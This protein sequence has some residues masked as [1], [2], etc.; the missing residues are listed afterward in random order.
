MSESEFREALQRDL[1][2]KRNEWILGPFA[3][4]PAT[5]SDDGPQ[6]CVI[7]GQ[8]LDMDSDLRLMLVKT[9]AKNVPA[10]AVNKL[11][12][13][14]EEFLPRN[15]K[16]QSCMAAVANLIP[17]ITIVDLK[18]AGKEDRAMGNFDTLNNF[19]FFPINEAGLDLVNEIRGHR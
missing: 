2:G 14:A 7:Y 5:V 11:T 3:T 4:R 6:E 13:I 1:G 18:L 17:S 10:A 16:W 19:T 15:A 9:F 12:S 8:F